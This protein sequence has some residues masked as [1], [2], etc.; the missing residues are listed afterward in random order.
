VA[1]C[2]GRLP[3]SYLIGLLDHFWPPPHPLCA[4]VRD[5]C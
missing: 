4:L 2:L 3:F 5:L 1:R